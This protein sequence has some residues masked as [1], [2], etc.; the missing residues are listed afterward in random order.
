M[1]IG[2]Q[3]LTRLSREINDSMAAYASERLEAAL[4]E[5]GNGL[6]GAQVLILGLAYRGGVKEATLSS[7]LLLARELTRRGAH[8]VVHDPLFDDAEIRAQGLEPSPLPPSA[9]MDAV[10]LQAAH[11]E[12]RELDAA[13]LGGARVFLDGRGS[14][15]RARFEVAGIRYIAIGA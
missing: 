6:S 13:Q 9:P 2:D 10:V 11:P 7:T 8:V 14:N 15:D 3:P 4:R 5:A 1:E 12:Y